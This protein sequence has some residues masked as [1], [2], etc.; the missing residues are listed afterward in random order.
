M[1]MIPQPCPFCVALQ[2]T[3]QTHCDVCGVYIR[4]ITEA[5]QNAEQ[6]EREEKR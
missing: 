2:S 5:S 6:I 1:K 4:T 3:D